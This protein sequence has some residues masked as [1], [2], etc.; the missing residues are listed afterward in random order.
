MPEDASER[1]A[2]LLRE[3]AF[4]QFWLA[5]FC[6]TIAF[7]MQAVAVGWQMYELTGNPLDLGLVGLVQFVPA[8]LLVLV[9]GHMA[10]RHDRRRIVAAAMAVAGLASALLTIGT[11]TGLLTRAWILGIVFVVGAGRAFESPTIFALLPALVPAPLLPRAVAASS[12]VGQSGM[13][14]GPAI[15]GVVYAISPV[16]VYAACCALFLIGSVLVLLLRAGAHKITREPVTLERLF[17]G[18]AFIWS[19]R[20]VLGAIMLDLFAVLLGAAMALLPIFA[21]DIL[22]V[23]P[24]G[25]GLLRAAPAVGAL[26]TSLVLTQ[27]SPKRRV[28]QVIFTAVASYGAATLLFALSTSL[29]LSAAALVALGAADM[30][31]VVARQ[32]LIQLYTPDAMRGRVSAVNSL[33]VVASNQLGDF[34]A[35]LMAAWLGAVPAVL[36]GAIG[37]LAVVLACWRMFPALAR[38]DRFETVEAK[39]V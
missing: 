28:G 16:G 22:D 26:I 1:S 38:V 12:A 5:R 34:R 17:A 39:S 23:G 30:V 18:I 20:I 21:R 25:L 31:S 14:I 15:G 35:G 2:S 33:F 11:A 27:I 6:T 36:I 4:V 32:T 19:N 29:I 10:D 9:A 13:I 37:T 7:H 24:G 8:F 3:R